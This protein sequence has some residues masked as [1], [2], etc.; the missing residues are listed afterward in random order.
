MNRHAHDTLE[1]PVFLS[2]SGETDRPRSRGSV[3]SVHG[4]KE[5][6]ATNGKCTEKKIASRDASELA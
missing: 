4:A 3:P 5:F 6:A 1:L 2:S